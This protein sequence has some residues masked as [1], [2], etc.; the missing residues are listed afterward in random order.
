MG[1]NLWGA[2]QV[3]CSAPHGVPGSLGFVTHGVLETGMAWRSEGPSRAQGRGLRSK[4]PPVLCIWWWARIIAVCC[5][6]GTLGD[7]ECRLGHGQ[8]GN[9]CPSSLRRLTVCGTSVCPTREMDSVSRAD[10]GT[11]L[12]FHL[13]AW[14][15]RVKVLPGKVAAASIPRIWC[16]HRLQGHLGTRPEQWEGEVVSVAARQTDRKTQAGEARQEEDVTAGLR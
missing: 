12:T 8:D 11:T 2:H 15:L 1:F 6:K 3:L 5:P 7:P 10:A 4:C 14:L 13:P 9:L 16:D